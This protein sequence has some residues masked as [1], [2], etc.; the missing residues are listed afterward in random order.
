MEKDQQINRIRFQAQ[1]VAPL[2]S[3][4]TPNSLFP[5]SLHPGWF[6]RL[7]ELGCSC[8]SPLCWPGEKESSACSCSPRPSQNEQSWC[9]RDRVDGDEVYSG[10]RNMQN[11]WEWRKQRDTTDFKEESSNRPTGGWKVPTE[12]DQIIF[13]DKSERIDSTASYPHWKQ[14]EHGEED[15]F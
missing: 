4:S 8:I 13:L 15:F 5:S 2:D 3:P 10:N 14:Q 11:W 1:G 7:R 12:T 6:E 9:Y